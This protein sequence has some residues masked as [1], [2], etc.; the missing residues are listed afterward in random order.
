MVLTAGVSDQ[1]GTYNLLVSLSVTTAC[2]TVHLNQLHLH[3]TYGLHW[4]EF[5]WVYWRI[6]KPLSYQL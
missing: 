2:T 5:N 4:I 1:A 3:F 6:K